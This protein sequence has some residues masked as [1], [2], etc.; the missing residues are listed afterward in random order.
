MHADT[1]RVVGLRKNPNEPLGLTVQ[2]DDSG[3]LVVAR[4]LAGGMIDHQ[5]LLHVGDVIL[6]VNGEPVESPEDLQLEISRAKD[7]V[8]FKIGPAI[9]TKNGMN[10]D[11]QMLNGGNP[12]NSSGKKL[13]VSG[14]FFINF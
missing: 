13:T 11:Y 2:Q 8:T 7:S 4:I 10:S 9:D 3:N 6:E 14:I 12:V 5:G 1:I